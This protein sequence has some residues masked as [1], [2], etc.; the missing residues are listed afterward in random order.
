MKVLA[1]L[2]AAMMVAGS[3]LAI[4]PSKKKSVL[5]TPG[6]WMFNVGLGMPTGD[7]EDAGVDTM[8]LV[9]LD[10]GLG[11][12]GDGSNAST[13]VGMAGLFG[14]GDGDF[15]SRSWGGHYGVIFG[16]SDASGN[17]PVYIKLQGGYYNG[18]IDFGTTDDDKWGFG[19]QAGIIWMPR[20]GGNDIRVE[21]GYYMMPSVSSVNNNG[22]FLG[23]GI[24]FQSR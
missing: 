8:V 7:H 23:I 5:Y 20:R 16:L 19:G 11:N 1:T 21:I 6:N 3:V 2:V 4:D 9:G 13:Y 15:E 14:S 24:P 22:W 18:R 10:Y 17:S 12:I